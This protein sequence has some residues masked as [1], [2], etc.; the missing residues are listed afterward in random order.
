MMKVVVSIVAL[1]AFATTTARASAY[2]SELAVEDSVIPDLESAARAALARPSVH[3]AAFA[4]LSPS[5]T[6]TTHYTRS[7]AAGALHK[8]WTKSETCPGDRQGFCVVS[9]G[10]HQYE[11]VQCNELTKNKCQLASTGHWMACTRHSAHRKLICLEQ[12]IQNGAKHFAAKQKVSAARKCVHASALKHADPIRG[13]ACVTATGK[14]L[15]CRRFDE[16]FNKCHVAKG[17]ID[18]CDCVTL[19]YHGEKFHGCLAPEAL[20]QAD[21][22]RGGICG[23]GAK[24]VVHQHCLEWSD[25]MTHCFDGHTHQQCPCVLKA[26]RP[27]RR[28]KCIAHS[29]VHAMADAERGGECR[30][31]GADMRCDEFSSD[32]TWCIGHTH[33]DERCECITKAYRPYPTGTLDENFAAHLHN[34]ATRPAAPPAQSVAKP[35]SRKCMDKKKLRLADYRRGGD[36]RVSSQEIHCEEYS[37]DFKWCLGHTHGDLKCDCILK[38]FKPRSQPAGAIAA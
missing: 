14:A 29:K 37:P 31:K 22:K 16:F 26:Y 7:D 34:L 18:D 25:D 32:F 30:V 9:F 8:P 27:K 21:P 5:T 4:Q 3:H 1:L 38:A 35:V 10:N 17:G 15:A 36:C 33:H 13:G 28:R 11:M 23:H 12:D 2:A 24:H 20:R 6:S 19:A